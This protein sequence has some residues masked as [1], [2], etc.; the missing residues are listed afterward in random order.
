MDGRPDRGHQTGSASIHGLLRRTMAAGARELLTV[1]AQDEF[2][3][4]STR[5]EAEPV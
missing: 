5:F 1:A 3:A 4:P 2:V